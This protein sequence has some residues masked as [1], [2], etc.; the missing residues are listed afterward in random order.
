MAGWSPKGLRTEAL[1]E[2]SGVGAAEISGHLNL[3][4]FFGVREGGGCGLAATL[5]WVA[6]F[7]LLLF[8]VS[9]NTW[10]AIRQDLKIL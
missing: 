6:G 5:T 8:F 7:L 3:P 1:V 2:A 4:S 10:T 9:R